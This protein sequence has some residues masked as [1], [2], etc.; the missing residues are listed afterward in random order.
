M[1]R[2]TENAY[3]LEDSRKILNNCKIMLNQSKDQLK[4]PGTENIFYNTS[5][6]DHLLRMLDSFEKQ[7]LN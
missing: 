5:R 2:S 3:D 4:R 1:K 6:L 7:Y